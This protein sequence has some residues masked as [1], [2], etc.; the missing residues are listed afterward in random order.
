MSKDNEFQKDTQIN[1]SFDLEKLSQE[2]LKESISQPKA[3]NGKKTKP[4]PIEIFPESIQRIIRE[5]N[6]ALNFPVDF[7]GAS[8]LYA[9][10]VAAGNTVQVEI[11]KGWHETA[12]LYM[13]LVGR[14]GTNKSHPLTFALQPIMA[15]DGAD[16]KEYE[17]QQSEYEY[18]CSL[19]KRERE[20]QNIPYPEK[21]ILKKRIVNDI[22]PEALA[23]VHQNNKR[24]LGVY[25]DELAGWL[26]NFNRYNA[27]GEQE[28]WISCFNAKP[29]IID[30]KTSASIRIKKPFVTVGGTI[31]TGILNEFSKDNRGLNGFIDRVLFAFPEGLKKETWSESEISDNTTNEYNEIIKKILDIPYK[32]E[33]SELQFTSDAYSKLKDWQAKNTELCNNAENEGIEGIYSKLEIYA[34]RFSLILQL[35]QYATDAG[36]MKLI[37]PQSVEGAIKLTEY[38]RSTA[39]KVYEI[40]NDANPLDQLPRNKRMFY[41]SLPDI[42][43]TAKAKEIGSK[44]NISEK[45]VRRFL[46]NKNYFTRIKTGY[47]EKKL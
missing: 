11:K 33:S 15:A 35:L 24:G 20:E 23:M 4:F 36:N 5:T 8:V 10:S 7:M 28:F 40:I 44:H 37:N 27:G 41:E 34:S 43:E 26:K 22:T 21:P 18:A 31:Q 12:V 32:G 9:A 14:P 29:I 19:T 6:K 16:Y 47:Y 45:T 2:S 38:F 30:R 3:K 1:P 13:A 39:E 46:N 17:K 25:V 42:T